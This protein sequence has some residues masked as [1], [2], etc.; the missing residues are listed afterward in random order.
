MRDAAL[1]EFVAAVER[2]L[3]QRRGREHV[4]VSPEFELA[5]QW[6]LAGVPIGTVMVGID[7]AFAAGGTP[8]S[9]MFCRRFVEALS[10]PAR[11]P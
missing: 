9:L 2:H 5:R 7:E 8:T 10:N 4:L 1:E 11:R 6:F 3:G